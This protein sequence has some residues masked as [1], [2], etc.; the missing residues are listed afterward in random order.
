VGAALGTT[1]V[2]DD[3]ELSDPRRRLV[4]GLVTA[5]SMIPS[6]LPNSLCVLRFV[7]SHVGVMAVG[8]SGFAEVCQID[9]SEVDMLEVTGTGT[10]THTGGPRF[11]GGGF[12]VEG[13]LEGMAV[14]A[15]LNYFMQTSTVVH[16][17]VVNFRAGERQVLMNNLVFDPAFLRVLLASVYER[18][19][20]ARGPTSLT[21]PGWYAHPTQPSGQRYWDGTKWTEHTAP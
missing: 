10:R 15:I 20:K 7:S 19:K 9:Y 4:A 14:A 2:S 5:A 8:H 13:A 16:D 21:P 17:T 11:F 1:R 12:G 18:I 3:E 6:V